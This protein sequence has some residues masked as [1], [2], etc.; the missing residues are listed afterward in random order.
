LLYRATQ[1]ALANVRKH[2]DAAHVE[3]RLSQEAGQFVLSIEDDGRGFDPDEAMR[4]RP[5]HL[6]LPSLRERVEMAGG[7]FQTESSPGAGSTIQ[8]RVPTI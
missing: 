5:G 2:A 6:G 3:V 1:E 4:V 7:F 8:I